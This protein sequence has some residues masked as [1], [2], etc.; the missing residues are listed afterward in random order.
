[1]EAACQDLV[2][3]KAHPT[4]STL[5]RLMAAID[6]DVKK[7]RPVT[8]AASTR[9]RSSVV[10]RDTVTDVYVRDASHYARNEDGK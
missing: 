2:N 3:R 4:Y 6:S 1:M 5:K 7:P 9:K 8:P 10:F